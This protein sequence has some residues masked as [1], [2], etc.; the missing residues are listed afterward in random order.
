MITTAA[1]HVEMLD[2]AFRLHAETAK[3]VLLTYSKNYKD[4]RLQPWPKLFESELEYMEEAIEIDAL[5]QT[6]VARV[7]LR[8]LYESG[9]E[10]SLENQLLRI[11]DNVITVYGTWGYKP[12]PYTKYD[13]AGVCRKY[14]EELIQLNSWP[15]CH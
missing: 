14:L 8:Q 11:V 9:A 12:N 6:H 15:M 2:T 7:E 13:I 10:L 4:G 3:H 5:A 1:H